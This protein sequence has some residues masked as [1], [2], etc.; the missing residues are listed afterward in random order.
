MTGEWNKPVLNRSRRGD[1]DQRTF[2]TARRIRFQRLSNYDPE[3]QSWKL[4]LRTLTRHGSDWAPVGE[5]ERGVPP[6]VIVLTCEGSGVL[7]STGTV[8]PSHLLSN[9]PA[10]RVLAGLT[11]KVANKL[12]GPLDVMTEKWLPSKGLRVGRSERPEDKELVRPF[13]P[14]FCL[15]A[16]LRARKIQQPK[17]AVASPL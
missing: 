16:A 15:A 13:N 1:E 14:L 5:S 6:I 9:S 10:C 11:K 8:L 12:G 2:L 4:C 3:T 7:E 17:P